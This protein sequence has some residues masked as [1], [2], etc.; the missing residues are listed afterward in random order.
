MDGTQHD[1]LWQDESDSVSDDDS[2]D[3]DTDASDEYYSDALS[4]EQVLQLLEESDDESDFEDF[5]VLCWVWCC[6]LILCMCMN[7]VYF[8]SK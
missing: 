7:E 1:I 6:S 4:H 3:I 8:V 5:W 2:E